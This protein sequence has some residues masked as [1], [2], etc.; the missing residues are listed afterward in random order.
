M[1]E[2]LY[3]QVALRMLAYPRSSSGF[4][5]G[6]GTYDRSQQRRTLWLDERHQQ[7]SGSHPYLNGKGSQSRP[8][9]TRTIVPD[10]VSIG[11]KHAMSSE[12]VL[13]LETP[14]R[15][16]SG[17]DR[18]K[19]RPRA[20]AAVSELSATRRCRSYLG[21]LGGVVVPAPAGL[22]GAVAGLVAPAP[23]MLGFWAVGLAGAGTPD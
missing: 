18:E 1:A 15:A 16:G 13:V 5:G 17:A 4:E 2:R 6:K 23:G 19:E 9:A 3:R 7:Q 22:A 12:S 14:R 10:R 11:D 21:W 20:I 8:A